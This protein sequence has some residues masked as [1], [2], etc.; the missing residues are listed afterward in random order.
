MTLLTIKEFN[1]ISEIHVVI[2]YDFS[3]ILNQSQ[4]NE[5]NKMGGTNSPGCPNCL[6]HRKYIIIHQLCKVYK[7]VI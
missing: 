1:D 3:V 2:Q 6:P 7:I 4:C 5:Q